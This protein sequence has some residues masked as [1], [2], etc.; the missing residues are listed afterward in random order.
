MSID[1]TVSEPRLGLDNLGLGVGLRNQHFPYLLE[2]ELGVQWFEIISENFIDN[3]GYD[4]YVLDTLRE[5]VPIVMHGVSMSIGSTEPLNWDYLHKL[6]QLAKEIEPKWISDHLCWTGVAGI[7][8]HDLLPMPLTEASLAH[9][10]QRICEVQDFLQRPLIIENPSTYLEFQ[11]STITEWAYLSRLTELT[12]CGLLL[13]VN[14][15]FVSATN[16]QFDPRHY[17]ESL[18]HDKIV[19]IHLAGPTKAN[20]CLID[21]HDKPVPTEVWHLYKQVIDKCGQVSTLLE[22]DANIPDYP[23]LLAELYKAKDVIDGIIPQVDLQLSHDEVI[24]TPVDHQMS[25]LL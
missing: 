17:I 23:E 24:S 4:R 1:K 20:N 6:K 5:K 3:Y 14:N 19:Q 18:P 25:V 13:D 21:T 16:H 11:Q 9:V 10:A 7:N 8:T 12:G 22:W 2:H 15:V